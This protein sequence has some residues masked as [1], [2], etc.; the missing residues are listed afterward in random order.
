[1]CGSSIKIKFKS[2]LNP[3]AAL[4]KANE[5][6]LRFPLLTSMVKSLF[7]LKVACESPSEQI[8]LTRRYQ[9]RR[10]FNRNRYVVVL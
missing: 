5:F 2:H 7:C 6:F 9:M 10:F 1:M 4:P 8:S 3:E